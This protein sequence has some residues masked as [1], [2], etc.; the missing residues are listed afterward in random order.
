MSTPKCFFVCISLNIRLSELLPL[1]WRLT[2]GTWFISIKC[3]LFSGKCSADATALHFTVAVFCTYT[4]PIPCSLEALAASILRWFCLGLGLLV[5]DP[6]TH[7]LGTAPWT[8]AAWGDSKYYP[9][10]AL[11]LIALKS[12]TL[13]MQIRTLTKRSHS[14]SPSLLKSEVTPLRFRTPQIESPSPAVSPNSTDPEMVAKGEWGGNALP[15]KHP[16]AFSAGWGVLSQAC[17]PG[18]VRR[19]GLDPCACSLVGFP[20][21][22]LSFRREEEQ[23][24]LFTL[25]AFSGG[26]TLEG[27]PSTVACKSCRFC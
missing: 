21:K 26:A 11:I 23:A 13:E 10:V 5:L 16:M 24:L 1:L 17:D 27:K 2:L 9:T 6:F 3:F 22:V 25:R 20:W 7:Q 18:K 8:I 14:Y 15:T 4:S 19:V 12:C